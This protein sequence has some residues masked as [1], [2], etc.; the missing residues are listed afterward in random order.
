[1]AQNGSKR[2]AAQPDL[3]DLQSGP[4]PHTSSKNV[5]DATGT[6]PAHTEAAEQSLNKFS[7]TITQSKSQGGSQA[8]LYA[9]GMTESDMDKPQVRVTAVVQAS[10]GHAFAI[11]E[12]LIPS[13]VK[14]SCMQVGISSVWW[15]GNPCNMHLHDLAQEVKEGCH[16]AG[17]VGLRFN[18]IGISDAISMG[19]DGMW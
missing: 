13:R 7:R 8:M 11:C 4:R 17:L 5:R 15:E 9:T 18:T 16:E 6:K 14:E 10:L 12:D 1:M 19:T 3:E 2:H